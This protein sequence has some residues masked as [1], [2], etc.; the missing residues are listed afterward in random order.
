[1]YFYCGGEVGHSVFIMFYVVIMYYV[2]LLVSDHVYNL[3]LYNM[4]HF[5]HL[6]TSIF[7]ILG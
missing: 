2:V 3:Y 6:Q 5:T 1:M 4:Y 7:V